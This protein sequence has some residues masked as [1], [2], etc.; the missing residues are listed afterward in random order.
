M[1]ASGPEAD[2]PPLDNREIL[3]AMGFEEADV[4]P[5]LRRCSSVDAAVEY[6]MLRHASGAG[7]TAASA[8]AA[9]DG[10]GN[11]LRRIMTLLGETLPGEAAEESSSHEGE[12]QSRGR[13]IYGALEQNWERMPGR[14]EVFGAVGQ[15]FQAFVSP[16]Q[17]PPSGD[18]A[19]G[20][21]SG[22]GGSAPAPAAAGG[23]RQPEASPAVAATPGRQEFEERAE[24]LVAT[25]TGL[26]FSE[27]DAKAAAKR[28]S[29]VEAAVEW[30]AAHSS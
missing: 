13:S 15:V 21:A 26:G 8:S 4:A 19:S 23:S 12:P 7:T 3:L 17:Q 1:A 29:S 6:I 18:G 25:L 2:E 20:G 30:L 14:G 27:A 28:C 11:F 9:P 5:A 24:Q 16:S 10:G 22:G